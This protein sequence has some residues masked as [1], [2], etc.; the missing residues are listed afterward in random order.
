MFLT[1]L[2]VVFL[3][4]HLVAAAGEGPD[5]VPGVGHLPPSFF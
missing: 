5:T 3:V 2:L 1:I 4:L